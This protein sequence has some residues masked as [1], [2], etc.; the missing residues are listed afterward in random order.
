MTCGKKGSLFCMMC[1]DFIYNSIVDRTV[2][3]TEI[4]LRLPQLGCP[5]QTL[6]RSI[7]SSERVLNE[8][9]KLFWPGLMATYP[10]TSFGIIRRASRQSL[11][12]MRMFHGEMERSPWVFGYLND[13]R[14]SKGLF[15][16]IFSMNLKRNHTRSHLNF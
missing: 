11:K 10:D 1:G 13:V 12:R 5:D 2:E 15:S 16:L 14:N 9:G 7:S 4:A 3:Y 6:E 8:T